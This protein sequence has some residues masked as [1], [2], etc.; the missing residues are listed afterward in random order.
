MDVTSDVCYAWLSEPE[1]VGGTLMCGILL[2][3]LVKL[4]SII[5][6][7]CHVKADDVNDL[8]MY[9]RSSPRL[10]AIMFRK[11]VEMHLLYVSGADNETGQ[12]S[13]PV[14]VLQNSSTMS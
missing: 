1:V 2:K 10:F 7:H 12:V 5:S 6:C 9:G 8:S 11:M 13:M 3:L 14:T 4:Y